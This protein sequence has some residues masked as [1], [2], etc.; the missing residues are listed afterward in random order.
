[1]SDV[2]RLAR[3]IFD[4]APW[5]G[6]D[7]ATLGVAERV[8]SM[9]LPIERQYY[10]WLAEHWALG[11]GEIVDL[12]AFVGGS[13]ACLAQGVAR[14]GRATRVHLYDR[15]TVNDLAKEKLL[16]PHGVAP[17]EGEDALPLVRDLLAPWQASVHL[18]PGDLTDQVWHGAPVEVLVVDIAKSTALADFVAAQWF[19]ALIPERSVVV[20][21]DFLHD[22]QPWLAAQMELFADFFLP[23]AHVGRDSISYLCL[24]RPT[25]AEIA[26][27]RLGACDDARLIGLVRQAAERLAPFGIAPRIEAMAA[28]LEA[29]PSCRS[30]QELRRASGRGWG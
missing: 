22:L 8:P 2:P 13:A 9:L 29:H 1:M 23:L 3:E 21:Q 5:A 19:G 18:H 17:F 6:A 28:L 15:F 10:V 30:A 25:P 16:Y 7:R 26:Q 4:A 27:R 14:A 20:Q 24:R 11:V 12:G